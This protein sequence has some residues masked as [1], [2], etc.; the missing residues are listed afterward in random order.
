MTSTSSTTT[1]TATTTKPTSNHPKIQPETPLDLSANFANNRKFPVGYDHEVYL[2]LTAGKDAEKTPNQVY[3]EERVRQRTTRALD[4]AILD[5]QGE[6]GPVD[7]ECAEHEG[8]K[9]RLR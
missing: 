7:F 6:P 2:Q 5:P 3:R 1:A 9:E 8:V 4:R